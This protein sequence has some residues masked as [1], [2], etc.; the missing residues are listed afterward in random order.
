MAQ[1]KRKNPDGEAVGPVAIAAPGL[2]GEQPTV[3]APA[4]V[5]LTEEEAALMSGSKTHVRPLVQWLLDAGA[6]VVFETCQ[7]VEG[8]KAWSVDAMR[9]VLATMEPD[10]PIQSMLIVQMLSAHAMAMKFS[11][12]AVAHPVPE[13]SDRFAHRAERLMNCF[14]EQSE[15]LSRLKGGGA[16]KQEI[17]VVKKL[18]V[19]PGGR[20]VVAGQIVGSGDAPGADT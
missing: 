17:T 12:R 10:D 6:N 1:G 9:A 4:R 16:S 18:N 15:T 3:Q 19:E 2:S 5:N 8:S 14:R 20:A 7:S 13:I 11:A